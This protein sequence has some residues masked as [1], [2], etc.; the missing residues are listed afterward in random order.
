MEYF[1][2]IYIMLVKYYLTTLPIFLIADFIWLSLIAKNF[3]QKH[4]G[5]LLSGGFRIVPAIIFYAL[6]VFGITV[7][8]IAPSIEKKSLMNALLLGGLFGLIAYATYDLTNMSTI[9]EWPL[10][11]TL[12]DLAW[13]TFVAGFV[14]VVV[15]KIFS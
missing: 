10:I 1:W 6:F 14:S 15:Y 2:Y 4:L 7:F 13:G 8:V 5:F 11:V 9:K 3:Y 12:V